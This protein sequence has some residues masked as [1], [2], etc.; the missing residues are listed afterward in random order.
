MPAGATAQS[1]LG[2]AP[3]TH[4]GLPRVL[5]TPRKQGGLGW[6]DPGAFLGWAGRH[7]GQPEAGRAMNRVPEITGATSKE[8][9]CQQ[10]PRPSGGWGGIHRERQ[11]KLGQ[12][13]PVKSLL[14]GSPLPCGYSAG[15]RLHPSPSAE[16]PSPAPG[17]PIV[18][19]ARS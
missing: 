19:P 4:N 11:E 14:G 9:G 10:V 16:T 15:G 3:W 1:A 13:G 2:W 6:R 8:T 18:A 7:F 12:T 5:C 17:T